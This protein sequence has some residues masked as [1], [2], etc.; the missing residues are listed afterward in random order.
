MK[1]WQI[2]VI[3][4]AILLLSVVVLRWM[5]SAL[6]ASGNSEWLGVILFGFIVVPG[7]ITAGVIY[8]VWRLGS[9]GNFNL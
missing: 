5:P 6:A 9:H 4:I 8:G 2:A 7:L 3:A 1:F